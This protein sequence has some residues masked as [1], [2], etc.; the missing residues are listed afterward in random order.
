MTAVK[1]A[2]AGAPRVIAEEGGLLAVEKPAGVPTT[3]PNGR[4]CLV[5]RVRSLVPRAEVCHP[6]SR[7]DR[8]VT[9]VV[10]FATTSRAIQV[11]LEAR[12][13]GT[14]QRLYVALVSPALHG[15]EALWS[16]PIAIDPRRKTYRVALEPGARGERAQD[17]QTRASVAARLPA[18]AILRLHPRS[19]RTHQL[20]VHCARAGAPI[21]GDVEY[22]GSPRI[23]HPDGTVVTARRPLLHCARVSLPGPGGGALRTFECPV[24]TDLR[25]AWLALGGDEKALDH[26]TAT[27]A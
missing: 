6:S 13:R 4:N 20:R 2:G 3:S 11:L 1:R 27:R 21:F 17:A 26:A 14:Y 15:D 8:D 23:V 10:I 5:E 12:R 19:G 9:G 16:W 24:P 18:A 22:G 25:A 7:L